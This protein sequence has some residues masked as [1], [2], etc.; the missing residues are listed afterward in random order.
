MIEEK[1]QMI[2]FHGLKGPRRKIQDLENECRK[3]N[4]EALAAPF[5]TIYNLS[6]HLEDKMEL[7]GASNS[8][9]EVLIC[10]KEKK[11][12]RCFDYI[13]IHKFRGVVS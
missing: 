13:R 10:G 3:L 8:K 11:K 7:S 9:Y 4:F 12:L 6:Y 2:Q 5:K 1:Q